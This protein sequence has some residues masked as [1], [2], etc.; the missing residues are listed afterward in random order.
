MGDAARRSPA[1]VIP[2]PAIATHGR[3]IAYF[4]ETKGATARPDGADSPA[5]LQELSS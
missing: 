1:D 4:T 5:G 2:S 3:A